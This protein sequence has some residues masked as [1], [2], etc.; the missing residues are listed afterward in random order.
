MATDLAVTQVAVI[1]DTPDDWFNWIFLRRDFAKDHRI[2]LYVNLDTPKESIPDLEAANSK[3]QLTDYKAELPSSLIYPL[4]IVSPT[5][6][7][8]TNGD[9]KR[10]RNRNRRELWCS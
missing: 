7:R 4:R 6:G 5:D 1:L 3:P 2:W 9:S 10:S 8:L